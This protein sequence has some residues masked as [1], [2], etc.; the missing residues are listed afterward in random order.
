[1]ADHQLN[2]LNEAVKSAEGVNPDTY[3]RDIQSASLPAQNIW[4]P[5]PSIPSRR[6]SYA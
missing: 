4:T 5:T 3:T 2:R 1:M 6:G